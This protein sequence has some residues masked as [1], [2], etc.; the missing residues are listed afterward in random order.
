MRIAVGAGH[1]KIVLLVPA[2]VCLAMQMFQRGLPV[3]NSAAR[4]PEALR[5]LHGALLTEHKH[6]AFA[7]AAEATLN[8][9][10]PP[11]KAVT[12]RFG[13]W[14]SAD[15]AATDRIRRSSAAMNSRTL[16]SV[17]G[18]RRPG[19]PRT[20]TVRSLWNRAPLPTAR[21]KARSLMPVSVRNASISERIWD[22]IS[23]PCARIC[24]YVKCTQGR[25]MH[26][27]EI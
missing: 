9:V 1:R 15:H 21:A 3:E 25:A 6:L 11:A 13:K 23:T 14:R 12:L 7:V 5:R 27:F 16:F 4:C 24:V 22:F 20:P 26:D 2:A 18:Q 19:C 10:E 8:C 17:S